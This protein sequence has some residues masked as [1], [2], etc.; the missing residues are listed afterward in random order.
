[1]INRKKISLATLTA[2]GKQR[3]VIFNKAQSVILIYI[4]RRVCAE[5]NGNDFI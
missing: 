5:K 3:R 1:M 4:E 2:A